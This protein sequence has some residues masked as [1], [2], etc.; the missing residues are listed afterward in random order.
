MMQIKICGMRISENVAAISELGPDMMGFIFYAPSPRSVQEE[1]LAL[2]GQVKATIET[3]AVFVME[4]VDHVIR[5]CSTYKF[6]FAQLH[7]GESAEC[8]ALVKAAGI[9]VIKVI[10][11]DASFEM[12]ELDV[13][14]THVDLFLF[15]TASAQHGGSGRHFDWS[16]LKN[17]SSSTPYL[18][19]GGIEAND[20]EQIVGMTLPGLVGIDANSRLESSPGVKDVM[21]TKKLI[22]NIR[23]R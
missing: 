8:C 9:K 22:E 4:P 10:S 19:S 18:L 20:I 13:Y 1:E 2:L 23:R 11:M 12:Q 15:D 5:I 21:K 14:E 3:V 16:L 6:D 7:G 17:Y